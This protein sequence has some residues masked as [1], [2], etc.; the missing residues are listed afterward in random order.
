MRYSNNMTTERMKA[1]RHRTKLIRTVT[2][3]WPMGREGIIPRPPIFDEDG[4]VVQRECYCGRWFLPS[5]N[6]QMYC[7]ERCRLNRYGAEYKRRTRLEAKVTSE[8]VVP[9]ALSV[10]EPSSSFAGHHVQEYVSE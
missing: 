5:S 10:A 3:D 2:G 7:R 8:V 1:L 4:F 9:H 6:L